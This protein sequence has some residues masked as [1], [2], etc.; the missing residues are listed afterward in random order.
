[1][2]QNRRVTWDALEADSYIEVVERLER[3]L[4]GLEETKPHFNRW[5]CMALLLART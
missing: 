4:E 1:M 5:G 3:K 2:W